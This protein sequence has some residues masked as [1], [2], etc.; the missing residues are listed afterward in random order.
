MNKFRAVTGD[1][2]REHMGKTYTHE[3]LHI[4]HPGAD[5]TLSILDDEKTAKEVA[6]FKKIGGATIV[7][8]TP[9]EMGRDLSS[10]KNDK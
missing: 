2:A 1:I 3:H 6:L 8:A 5:Q 4:H 10:L 9:P 7:E